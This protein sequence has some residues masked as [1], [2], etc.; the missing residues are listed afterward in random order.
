MRKNSDLPKN[1]FDGRFW[2]KLVFLFVPVETD[3]SDTVIDGGRIVQKARR[4]WAIQLVGVGL[5]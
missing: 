1:R 4:E 5:R 2:L 3:K